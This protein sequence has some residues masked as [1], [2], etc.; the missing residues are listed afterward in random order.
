MR[1]HRWQNR[2]LLSS[3]VDTSLFRTSLTDSRLQDELSVDGEQ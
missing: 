3:D 1:L 2:T